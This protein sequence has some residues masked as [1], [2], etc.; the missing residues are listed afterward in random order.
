MASY[1]SFSFWLLL[2][3]NSALP[4]HFQKNI[5]FK[6]SAAQELL[7][8]MSTHYRHEI[9]C[10]AARRAAL[11]IVARY[12]EGYLAAFPRDLIKLIAKRVWK[13]REDSIWLDASRRL[14]QSNINSRLK[15][16]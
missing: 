16:L 14:G 7:S 12:G 5:H 3:D 9:M 8:D 11:F 15:N 10:D 2:E 4:K 1:R 6:L 13:T